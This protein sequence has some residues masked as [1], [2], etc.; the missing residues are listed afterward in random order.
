MLLAACKQESGWQHRRQRSFAHGRWF[1]GPAMG[2]PQFERTGLRGVLE[3]PASRE[4]AIALCEAL[5][6][7]AG[8][9]KA[10]HA[11]CQHNDT[12]ALG[13]ARLLL[14]R[15]PEPLPGRRDEAEGWRQYV[16]AWRP[17][18]ERPEHWADSWSWAWQQIR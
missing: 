7:D 10:L 14:W 16:E 1:G 9:V 17:G 15:L 5:R 2:W 8:D 6:Y 4:H 3:H 18:A 12:L 13:M 11:A